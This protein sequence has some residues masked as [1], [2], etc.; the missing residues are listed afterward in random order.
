MKSNLTLIPTAAMSREEWL[1]YRF[2]GIGASEVGSILGLDDYTSSLE[3]FYYKIGDVPKFDVESMRQ[4]IGREQEDFIATMWQYWGGTQDSMIA[5]YRADRIIRKC[6]RVNAFVR[7]PKYPWLYVS[8]D[9]KINKYGNRDE[10]TLELK[11][12]GKWEADKWAG[13][14]PPKYVTQV[15]TQMLVCEFLWGEI[16]LFE[17]NYKMDVLPFDIRAAIT[18]AIV[19]RTK[20][21]WDRVVQGRKLVNEKYDAI[22]KYNQRRVDDL[23]QAIDALAPEPDGSLAYSEYLSERYKRADAAL[24]RGTSTELNL[25]RLHTMYAAEVKDKT[26][27]KLRVENELKK[28]MGEVQ[29]LEFGSDGKLYWSKSSNGS[30]VFRNKI[31]GMPDD[32]PL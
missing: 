6:Q 27:Q 15:N 12:I 24:R 25:A 32:S 5:N 8:L 28:S 10:G 1:N 3:L 2:S 13:S 23:N 21:F 22:Q 20:A 14:L 19:E 30:R 18:D 16:A 31:K 9:R 29:V 11:T 26:E 7:N 4:F 17:D